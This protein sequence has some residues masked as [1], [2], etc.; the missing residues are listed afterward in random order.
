MCDL[1]DSL[2]TLV[3]Y[4]L[5]FSTRSIK[6]VGSFSPAGRTVRT[7]RAVWRKDDF[8]SSSRKFCN[9]SKIAR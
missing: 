4:I 1:R 5:I 9:N 2:L 8:A 3:V 6:C 7:L